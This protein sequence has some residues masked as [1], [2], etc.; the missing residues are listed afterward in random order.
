[1]YTSHLY[2]D[3]Q[4]CLAHTPPYFS[5]SSRLKNLTAPRR[6]KPLATFS[7]PLAPSHSRPLSLALPTTLPFSGTFLFL[8][9]FLS[10][11]GYVDGAGPS[12]RESEGLSESLRTG[13]GPRS[14]SLRVCLKVCGL[15]WAL[16]PRAARSLPRARAR[17]ALAAPRAARAFQPQPPSAAAIGRGRSGGGGAWGVA[18]SIDRLP[19]SLWMWTGPVPP[20]RLTIDGFGWRTQIRLLLDGLILSTPSRGAYVASQAERQHVQHKL[21]HFHALS[22]GAIISHSAALRA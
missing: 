21:P 11:E 3:S 17:R 2:W 6:M 13:L 12:V 18:R 16:G 5:A 8:S 1:M 9:L 15:G 7:F 20:I 4:A 22:V 19:A 14:G 10:P